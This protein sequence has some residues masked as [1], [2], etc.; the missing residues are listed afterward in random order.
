LVTVARREEVGSRRVARAPLEEALRGAE[1]AVLAELAGVRTALEHAVGSVAVNDLT[2]GRQVVERAGDLHRR[3][4]DVHERLLALVARQAPVAGDL[5]LA[6]ALLHVNDRLERMSAQC[7]N[8]VTL[9]GAFPADESPSSGQLECLSGMAALADEQM[10]QAAIVF[11]ERDVAGARRLVEHDLGINESNR[12]C[13]ALAVRDGD[14]EVRREVA[15]L[16]AL[17]ARA[18]ER[19]GDNAVDIGRQAAFIATGR[20][21]RASVTEP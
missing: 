17:M 12:R 5:R 19:I 21:E 13:F 7:V 14:D 8:I 20:L 15:F 16:V 2:L 10:A 18:I 6:T 4:D 3:Y 9:R 11:A 1:A